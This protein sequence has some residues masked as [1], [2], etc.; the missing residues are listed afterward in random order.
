MKRHLADSISLLSSP[1]EL[2]GFMQKHLQY[3][4]DSQRLLSRSHGYHWKTPEETFNDGFGFCYDLAAFSAWALARMGVKNAR[5]LLVV[6]GRWGTET[7]SGHFV[8]TWQY[9]GYWY[10]FDNGFFKGPFLWVDLLLTASRQRMVKSVK[11]F[12][13][14]EVPW[15]IRYY[16]MSRFSI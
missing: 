9:A 16:D 2:Q 3:A 15:H 8:C 5:L 6:W 13:L 4:S 14:S 10:C 12:D 7:N 11:W 1:E